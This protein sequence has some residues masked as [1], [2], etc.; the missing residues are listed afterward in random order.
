MNV[1]HPGD[2]DFVIDDYPEIVAH[3]GGPRIKATSADG[4]D[5]ELLAVPGWSRPWPRPR[6]DAITSDATEPASG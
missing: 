1:R 6:L 2:P 5:T 3:F 4:P